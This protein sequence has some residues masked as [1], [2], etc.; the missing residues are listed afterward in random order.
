MQ[1]NQEKKDWISGILK[2]KYPFLSLEEIEIFLSICTYK[3]IKNKEIVIKSGD[4]SKTL[5]FIL[6][7]T[8]RGYF[9]NKENEE[10][11]IFLRQNPTFFGC[12]DSLFADKPTQFTIESILPAKILLLDLSNF[13]NLAFENAGIF[14]MY[15]NEIKSQI[16]NVISRIESLIDKQP[17]ERYEE[18][19]KKNPKL[20]QTAFNKHIANFL[21]ITPVSLSR[22]IKRTKDQPAIKKP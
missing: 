3:E 10:I 20:F 5:L 1:I 11:N 8:F 12:H 9:I 7:G 6:D 13:E 4:T 21:G 2:D 16:S 15:I 22:I 18:L 14:K 19:L 17:Q